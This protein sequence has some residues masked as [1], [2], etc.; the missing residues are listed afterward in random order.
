MKK[1]F[2]HAKNLVSDL[3]HSYNAQFHELELIMLHMEKLEN[4]VNKLIKKRDALNIIL[5]YPCFNINFT[6][7]EMDKI[8]AQAEL[9]NEMLK[10]FE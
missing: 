1:R 8:N 3:Q 5:S 7:E 4:L 10:G 2:L 9:L 6:A